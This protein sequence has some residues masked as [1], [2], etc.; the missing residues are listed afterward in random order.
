[1]PAYGI[2]PLRIFGRTTTGA[3]PRKERPVMTIN[4]L[5]DYCRYLR[6]ES[7]A[8]GVP[9][10][11][12]EGY[13]YALSRVMY[14]CHEGLTDEDRKSVAEWREKHWKDAE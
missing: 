7:H 13:K 3:A 11:W 6:D 2:L 5:H 1:M 8:H 10:E 12:S 9:D 14:K 4:E